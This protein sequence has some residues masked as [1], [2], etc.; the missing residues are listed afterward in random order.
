MGE[1]LP[2][3]DIASAAIKLIGG[4]VILGLAYNVGGKRAENRQRKANA[5]ALE[6]ANE[7]T[8][9][10]VPTTLDGIDDLVRRK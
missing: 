8:Q 1:M 10:P 7:I 4:A 2:W 9:G 6:D 3:A 5:E